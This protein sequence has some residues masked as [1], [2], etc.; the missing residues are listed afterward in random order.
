MSKKQQNKFL[1][2]NN[3]SNENEVALDKALAVQ[4]TMLPPF[5]REKTRIFQKLYIFAIVFAI[6][7]A[8]GITSFIMI[9]DF[10]KKYGIISSTQIAYLV[11]TLIMWFITIG[12]AMLYVWWSRTRTHL[13]TLSGTIS[14]LIAPLTLSILILF[15]DFRDVDA[16]DIEVTKNL[17]FTM[18]VASVGAGAASGLLTLFVNIWK[19]KVYREA[20]FRSIFTVFGMIVISASPLVLWLEAKDSNFG[21]FD[22]TNFIYSFVALFGGAILLTVGVML[23]MRFKTSEVKSTTG[24]IKLSGS[25]PTII[26]FTTLLAIGARFLSIYKFDL[27]LIIVI[28]IDVVLLALFFVF[29]MFKGKIK[30]IGHTNPLFNEFVVKGFI[31]IVSL[32]G[33]IFIAML[34]DL[35]MVKSYAPLSFSILAFTALTVMII[36]LAAH[37]MNLIVFEKFFKSIVITAV[38]TITLILVIVFVLGTLK[39]TEVVMQIVARAITLVFLIAAIVG[40]IVLLMLDVTAIH[41]D[42]I[43][44]SRVSKRKSKKNTDE[45]EIEESIA[46]L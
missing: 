10:P 23:S 15:L 45:E 7:I 8:T 12:A 19:S 21:S 40:E 27:P 20:K 24:S 2:N 37:F 33:L 16:N 43:H 38:V 32:V 44:T 29:L 9:D 34:P 35:I 1:Y 25:L 30:N 11:I 3:N 36:V 46:Q 31:I 13:L 6:A 39:Q 28:V 17:F 14:A 18:G 41:K 22:V 4:P 42:V 26:V 5:F